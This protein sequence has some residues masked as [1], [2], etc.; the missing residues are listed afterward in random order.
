MEAESEV[1]FKWEY[2]LKG[3]EEWKV[4]VRKVKE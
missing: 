4:R 2:V 1:P 3:P